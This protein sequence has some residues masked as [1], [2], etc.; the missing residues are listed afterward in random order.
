MSLPPFCNIL[1]P[2]RPCFPDIA[3][4]LKAVDHAI[5]T[6]VLKV[7]HPHAVLGSRSSFFLI[8]MI[9]CGFHIMHS[10]PTCRWQG[11]ERG[12]HFSFSHVTTTG[13]MGGT[14][15]LFCSHTLRVDSSV[16]WTTGSA[17]V[18]C[19]CEVPAVGEGL[20][21]SFL[22]ALYCGAGPALLLQ[23]PVRGHGLPPRTSEESVGLSTEWFQ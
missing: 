7:Q 2:V 18:C 9:L 8:L 15:Q 16:S 1:P 20:G 19:P 23:Y 17:L 14:G 3:Q 6:R 11:A 22:S 13:Q 10:D 5:R 12:G 21:P 4:P